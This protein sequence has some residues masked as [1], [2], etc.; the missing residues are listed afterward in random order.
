MLEFVLDLV[1]QRGLAQRR[2]DLVIDGALVAI[3]PQSERDVA[4]D[5]HRER[6]GLLEDHPDVTAHGDRIDPGS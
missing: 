5:A 6:I 4:K 2:F 1:P 3:E